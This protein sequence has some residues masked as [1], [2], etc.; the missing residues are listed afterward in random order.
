[1][2][3]K[4]YRAQKTD[5]TGADAREVSR[6]FA[7]DLLNGNTINGSKGRNAL[8]TLEIEASDTDDGRSRRIELAHSYLWV[9]CSPRARGTVDAHSGNRWALFTNAELFAFRKA[10][11]V[12]YDRAGIHAPGPLNKA[13]IALYNE[14]DE[15]ISRRQRDYRS[16]EKQV[17]MPLDH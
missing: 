7:Y 5:T 15:E 9:E 6:T 14:C 12:A 11:V 2:S 13:L 3:F 16:K 1:M 10:A 17:K 4:Y 8:R